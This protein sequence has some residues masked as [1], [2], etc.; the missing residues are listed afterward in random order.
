MRELKDVES[1]LHESAEDRFINFRIEEIMNLY[2]Y[3]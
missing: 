2:V 3:S 1:D